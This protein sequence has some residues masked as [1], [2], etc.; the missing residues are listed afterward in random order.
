MGSWRMSSLSLG[1][2]PAGRSD[3]ESD[4]DHRPTTVEPGG[5]CAWTKD[6][7]DAGSPGTVHVRYAT[8]LAVA[9]VNRCAR[10]PMAVTL[11]CTTAPAGA[12]TPRRRG[13]ASRTATC[14][15]DAV[16]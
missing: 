12:T 16:A 8:A 6:K 4:L 5:R 15:F 14:L 2:R 3:T 9:A 10:A 11:D 1:R 13:F 7:T